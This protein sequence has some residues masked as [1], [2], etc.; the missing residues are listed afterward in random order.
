[1]SSERKLE[2][3]AFCHVDSS[4]A[5]AVTK[6]FDGQSIYLQL[7]IYNLRWRNNMNY[8]NIIILCNNIIYKK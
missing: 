4:S 6:L 8:N 3:N 1:M 5:T 7:Q 2:S